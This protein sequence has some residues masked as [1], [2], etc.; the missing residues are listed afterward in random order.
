MQ[1]DLDR[2]LLPFGR[3]HQIRKVSKSAHPP[4]PP[5]PLPPPSRLYKSGAQTKNVKVVI[6]VILDVEKD[7]VEIQLLTCA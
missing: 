3:A 4:I 6:I 1:L 5:P 2:Y 7:V